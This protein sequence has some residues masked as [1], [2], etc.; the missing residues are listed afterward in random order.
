MKMFSTHGAHANM[1]ERT[2]TITLLSKLPACANLQSGEITIRRDY[3]QK[4][5][6]GT[7]GEGML[8][9]ER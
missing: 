5:R 3:L 1:F 4:V 7:T 6:N 2:V 9:Q 8:M